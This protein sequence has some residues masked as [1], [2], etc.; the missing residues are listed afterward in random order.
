MRGASALHFVV[1]CDTEEV[2]GQWVGW[3]N[4]GGHV[5]ALFRV[6]CLHHLLEDCSQDQLRLNEQTIIVLT[7]YQSSPHDLHV[8]Y[9]EIDDVQFGS[10]IQGFYERCRLAI[11]S[12]L[13]KFTQLDECGISELIHK[14]V[15]R[16]W[17]RHID[18]TYPG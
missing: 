4:E 7:P 11:E 14:A 8:G 5:R 13:S 6:L 15:K 10:P 3:H 16:R 12:F 9:F 1:S 18:V 17:E 2:K